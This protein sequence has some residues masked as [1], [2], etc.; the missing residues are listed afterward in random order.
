MSIVGHGWDNEFDRFESSVAN[1][2]DAPRRYGHSNRNN[3]LSKSWAPPLD[4]HETEKE[5][6]VNAELPGVNKD[7]INVDIRENALIISGETKHNQEYKEGSTHIQER[8]YGS[9]HRAITLPSNV[10][11]NEITAKFEQGILE[12]K[13]PKGEAPGSRKV[14]I[15]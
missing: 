4:V 13:I 9:F 11:S 15:Q 10:K 14:A 3:Q 2:F 7:K 8:R 5:Y 1:L 12:V 6:I